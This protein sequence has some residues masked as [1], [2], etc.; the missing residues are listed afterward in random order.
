MLTPQ[1]N[2]SRSFLSSK[3]KH[4][5][6]SGISQKDFCEIDNSKTTSQTKAS[7]SHQ[8][9]IREE[10]SHQSLVR[11]LST[12]QNI[13]NINSSADVPPYS[14]SSYSLQK[15][16]TE[17]SDSNFSK[18]TKNSHPEIANLCHKNLNEKESTK[19]AIHNKTLQRLLSPSKQ[20]KLKQPG[21]Q[22]FHSHQVSSS[23]TDTS[24][25]FTSF[26][27]LQTNSAKPCAQDDTFVNLLKKNS[28][29]SHQLSSCASMELSDNPFSEK[30][31]CL[32]SFDDSFWL[33]KEFEIKPRGSRSQKSDSS[34]Q[35]KSSVSSIAGN[36]SCDS[37][38]DLLKKDICSSKSYQGFPKVLNNPL[39]SSSTPHKSIAKSASIELN[40][41]SP[42]PIKRLSSSS[43]AKSSEEPLPKNNDSIDSLTSRL[44]KVVEMTQNLQSSLP[45]KT[46]QSPSCNQSLS[47]EEISTVSAHADLG[48]IT[49]SK[50]KPDSPNAIQT[51]RVVLDLMKAVNSTPV[52]AISVDPDVEMIKSATSR[53]PVY[54]D[55]QI[56]LLKK[57]IKKFFNKLDLESFDPEKHRVKGMEM[58]LFFRFEILSNMS[59][60]GHNFSDISEFISLI[61]IVANAIL[62][63]TFFF[64]HFE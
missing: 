16:M 10:T 14:T 61:F 41:E 28:E 23:K 7:K 15:A 24:N 29:A 63:H 8:I 60:F 27:S 49:I 38:P 37:A 21:L 47:N 11:K 58:S 13:S 6:T 36:A 5:D 25:A 1:S 42:S 48:D 18:R 20:D 3:N 55:A 64:L 50:P 46:L 39:V 56:K 52:Q 40:K 33:P 34:A 22:K 9:L 43:L 17:R 30:Y 51:G 54:T 35:K 4:L 31:D 19:K 59:R 53:E 26:S 57:A 45:S 12:K 44:P 2:T 32:D 62:A